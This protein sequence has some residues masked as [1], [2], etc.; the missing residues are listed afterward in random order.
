MRSFDFL[1]EIPGKSD[2][3]RLQ[4]L[5]G[6]SHSL[7]KPLARLLDERRAVLSGETSQDG[8]SFIAAGLQY[9]LVSFILEALL[10]SPVVIFLDDIHLAD[11][12]TIEFLGFLRQESTSRRPL[13]SPL[14]V[15]KSSLFCKK[16]D[17]TRST[18][19]WPILPRSIQCGLSS[20]RG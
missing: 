9:L 17:F 1:D 15:R 2:T 11:S 5:L 7:I 12:A 14:S 6:L 10:T 19:F 18:N 13:F 16:P 20:W 3:E 8:E 4:A